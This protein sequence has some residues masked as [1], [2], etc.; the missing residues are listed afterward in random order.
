MSTQP[1][2]GL[3]NDANRPAPT[4]IRNAWYLAAWSKDIR[5]AELT[6]RVILDQPLV[7]FRDATCQ[8]RALL[9][10]CPHRSVPLHLGK[11]IDGVLECA[12]HGLR[13]DG[14]GACI[15]NPHGATIPQR[16]RV[17]AYSVVE[18]AGGVWIWMG[19]EAARQA[20]LPPCDELDY[21]KYYVAYDYFPLSASYLLA[22]DNILDL[23]HLQFLHPATLGSPEM[24]R[25]ALNIWQVGDSVYSKRAIRSERLPKMLEI[26]YQVAPG[27]LVDRYLEVTWLPASTALVVMGAAEAG[28]SHE[29]MM[30]VNIWLSFT[31]ETATS[32]HYFFAISI[33]NAIKG[34]GQGAAELGLKAL[35]IP[36][37]REDKQIMEAQQRAIS[38]LGLLPTDGVML[39][40]DSAA[41]R[42]RRV[43]SRL[44]AAEQRQPSALQTMVGEQFAHEHPEGT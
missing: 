13:F 35:R 19:E 42:A 41:M 32:C 29:R 18:H 24:E 38:G 43:L 12:Y 26:A 14:S 15:L 25:G 44:I 2:L 39:A 3:A 27:T 7:I 16:A 28:T 5:V 20:E 34:Y 33:S 22:I 30:A 6:A 31:P 21:R 8:V 4:Y 1:Y 23:S 9:D 11:L 17:K 10:R 40:G 37:E 36:F